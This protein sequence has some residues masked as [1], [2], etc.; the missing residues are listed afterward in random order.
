[1]E[2]KEQDGFDSG[3]G[4][5]SNPIVLPEVIVY[6]KRPLPWYKRAINGVAKFVN[7]EI[8]LNKNNVRVKNARAHPKAMDAV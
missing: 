8:F 2:N 4:S 6:G 5:S 3:R 7:D 1:M